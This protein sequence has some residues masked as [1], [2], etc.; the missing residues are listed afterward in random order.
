MSG[1]V[2]VSAAL[3]APYTPCLA[4]RSRSRLSC[5][6][7]GDIVCMRPTATCLPIQASTRLSACAYICSNDTYSAELLSD[8]TPGNALVNLA[9]P[10]KA[11]AATRYHRRGPSSLPSKSGRVLFLCQHGPCPALRIYKS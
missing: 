2:T 5:V 1:E 4:T 6:C 3:N 7:G 9:P 10:S 8:A 11:V